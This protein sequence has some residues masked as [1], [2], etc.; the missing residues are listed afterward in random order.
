MAVEFQILDWIQNIRTP[1]GDA[2]MCFVTKLGNAGM[3]WI[4]AA[5]VLAVIPRTRK[6]GIMMMAALLLDL[7]VCNGILKNLVGKVRPCDINTAI[8]LPY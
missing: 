4:I 2:F 1:A 8:Q 3:I 5:I 7:V 6:A